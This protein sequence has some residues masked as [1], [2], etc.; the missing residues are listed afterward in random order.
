MWSFYYDALS[1]EPKKGR[2]RTVAWILL[3][4]PLHFV[5]LLLIAAVVNDI[6][7]VVIDVMPLSDST[8]RIL[9]YFNGLT[10]ALGKVSD[11]FDAV[12]NNTT[13][14]GL[15]AF[16]LEMNRLDLYPSFVDKVEEWRAGLG[17]ITDP[18]SP[19]AQALN[20]NILQYFG[21]VIFASATLYGVQLDKSASSGWYE[22][23]AAHPNATLSDS[24][25]HIVHV[26]EEVFA[27]TLSG[28]LW[29][30]PS[31]GGSLLLSLAANF[32]RSGFTGAFLELDMP[33]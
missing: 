23:V 33:C 5:L 24:L 14:P 13:P 22:F 12:A 20:S 26:L 30:F 29:A 4:F 3:H 9:A 17:N 11:T 16:A 10:S 32:V 8:A 7:Y 19:A 25:S 27:E 1:E 31:A 2:K 18:Q 21:S 28:A 15:Q 6:R